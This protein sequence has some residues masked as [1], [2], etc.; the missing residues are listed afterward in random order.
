MRPPLDL[1]RQLGPSS[2]PQPQGAKQRVQRALGPQLGLALNVDEPPAPRVSEIREPRRLAWPT[3]FRPLALAALAGGAI[4]ASALAMFAPKHTEIVYVDRPGPAQPV[5]APA[6]SVSE[7]AKPE[8]VEATPNDVS[9]A[10]VAPSPPAGSA[11]PQAVAANA[12]A[13]ARER[14][15]LDQARKRLGQGEAAAAL[16]L[17]E[18]HLREHPAGKLGEERDAIAIRALLALG[19]SEEAGQRGRAFSDRYPHSL[20]APAL[21]PALAKP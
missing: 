2:V 21:A 11:R 13:L 5:L 14:L 17:A 19:R 3:E 4:T 1:L 18:R 15:L 9:S 6:P 8:A 12:S 16:D 7:L 20:I 10:V